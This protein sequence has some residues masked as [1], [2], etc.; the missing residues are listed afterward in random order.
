MNQLVTE[1]EMLEKMIFQ[2]KQKIIST[3]IHPQEIEWNPKLISDDT[4]FGKRESIIH[5]DLK[6]Y[7]KYDD[8]I[9]VLSYTDR[10]SN[11][12]LGDSNFQIEQIVIP[13][14]VDGI[15]GNRHFY[16]FDAK[17][18]ELHNHYILPVT[19]DKRELVIQ[20]EFAQAG[21]IIL[22]VASIDE[23]FQKS[24][25]LGYKKLVQNIGAMGH[26]TWMQALSYGY[27]G[28]VFAGFLQKSLRKITDVDGYQKAQLFAI[29]IG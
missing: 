9:E 25:A 23:A 10:Y 4:I 20:E 13:E 28:S 5:Y 7:I 6:K 27:E 21:V 16:T 18:K 17:N 19:I 3:N 15:V 29:A 26:Y 22:F 8:L 12:F 2:S 11:Q 1:M 14:R 24:G